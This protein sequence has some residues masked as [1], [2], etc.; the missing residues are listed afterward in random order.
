MA[1]SAT[2]RRLI[3]A[4]LFFIVYSG[5]AQ[6][7]EQRLLYV[8]APGIRNDLQY[9]GA[10]ILVFDIDAGHKFVKRHSNSRQPPRK[11]G[12]H[13]G[14]LRQRRHAQTLFHHPYAPRMP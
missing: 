9:G 8:G 12:E 14:H 3:A 4:F 10:G 1:T 7:E 13:Q 5:A 11:T 2:A 6:A